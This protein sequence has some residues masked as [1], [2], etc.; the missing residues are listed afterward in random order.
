MEPIV[1]PYNPNPSAQPMITY[2]QDASGQ[3]IPVIAGGPEAM[4][5]PAGPG[6]NPPMPQPVAPTQPGMG[7]PIPQPQ[8]QP[9]PQ[10]AT[11]PGVTPPTPPAMSFP[12]MATVDGPPAQQPQQFPG[13][14]P[15]ELAGLQAGPAKT[16]EE[17]QVRKNGWM[18]FIDG[19][20]SD[21]QKMAMLLH[22][23]TQLVQP[24]PAGQ[25]HLGHFGAAVADS[26]NYLASI[27][28]QEF[29][30]R[31][32]QA[33]I[34]L[35]KAQTGT[36]LGKPALQ[37]AQT[38]GV[39]A[40]TANTKAKTATLDAER[41]PMVS[42]LRAEVDKLM[43][44]GSLD[45]AKGR[46]LNAQAD[47]EPAKVAEEIELM[48]AHS[49]Y[50]RHPGA[51]AAAHESARV[52]SIDNLAKAYVGGGDPELTKLYKSDPATAL[53]QAKVKAAAGQVGS[54]WTGQQEQ[55]QADEIYSMYSSMYDRLNKSGSKQAK[56]LSKEEFIINQLM[57]A[58]IPP[59]VTSKVMARMGPGNKPN[60]EPAK[61]G[62]RPPLTSFD[63][64]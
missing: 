29:K 47:A 21:P 34:D 51:A 61:P 45:K 40:D 17:A 14:L 6:V 58:G 56:G 38:S 20:K 42:K 39:V 3:W 44:D 59:T 55:S 2:Q 15:P 1:R 63:K 27:R 18:T 48:K 32:T 57:T 36:E 53:N 11:A 33:D 35:K 10:E 50:F 5:V 60:E 41:A 13:G 28:A 16:P 46:L 37:T 49:W 31:E 22:F 23:G 43:S 26:Q 9:V 62:T 64:K 24:T 52:Q 19:V 25:T 30:N 4:P 8:P 12:E 54:Y 7:A